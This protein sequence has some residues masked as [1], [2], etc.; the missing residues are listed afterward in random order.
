[1]RKFERG[2]RS[3][4]VLEQAS[5]LRVTRDIVGRTSRDPAPPLLPKLALDNGNELF[6][7]VGGSV[8]KIPRPEWQ[9]VQGIAGAAGL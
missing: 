5:E 9:E 6:S 7:P 4:L 8:A 2:K 3:P 1:M